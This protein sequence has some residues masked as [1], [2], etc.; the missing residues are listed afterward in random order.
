[1]SPVPT[2]AA[3]SLCDAPLQDYP[4]CFLKEKIS[5]LFWPDVSERVT[6]RTQ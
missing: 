1:M 5:N 3:A 6:E 2:S 4:S